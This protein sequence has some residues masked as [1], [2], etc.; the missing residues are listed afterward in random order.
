MAA[1]EGPFIGVQLAGLVQH[2]FRD[3]QFAH[4]VQERAN[5]KPEHGVAVET[6][7]LCDGT[8]QLRDPLTVALRVAVFGFNRLAPAPCHVQE[9]LLEVGHPTVHVG[10]VGLGAQNRE[11]TVRPIEL[12]QDLP[13]LARTPCQIGPFA[14]DFRL[15][16]QL[17]PCRRQ[18][19]GALK[20]LVR[21]LETS[22]FARNHPKQLGGLPDGRCVARLTG[23]RQRFTYRALRPREITALHP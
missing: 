12:L 3:D 14:G 16:E 15:E 21:F 6:A 11:E 17:A 20:V 7:A 18:L 10:Q 5:P 22:R 4:V 1:H 13:V 9:L 2:L 19:F 8:G 23:G